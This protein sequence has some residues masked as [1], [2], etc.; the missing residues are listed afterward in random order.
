MPIKSKDGS[1]VELTLE[2]A[3]GAP[4]N[5]IAYTCELKTRGAVLNRRMF[6]DCVRNYA[7]YGGNTP[8]VLFHA[9]LDSAAHPD[10]RKAH[11]RISALQIGTMERRGMECDTLEAKFDWINEATRKDVETGA[12]DKCSVTIFPYAVDE[13]TGEEIGA[14]L[15]SLSLTNNPAL[16]DLPPL[17]AERS[18]SQNQTSPT[19]VHKTMSKFIA[20]AAT[21]G[22]VCRDEDQALENLNALGTEAMQVRRSLGATNATETA[23]K[24]SAAIQASIELPKVKAEIDAINAA[25]KARKEAEA[26]K[27]EADRVI[28]LDTLCKAKPHLA[29]M[30]ESLEFHSKSDWAGFQAK[31]PLAATVNQTELEKQHAALQTVALGQKIGPSNGTPGPSQLGVNTPQNADQMRRGKVHELAKQIMQEKK[32][33]FADALKQADRTVP[34]FFA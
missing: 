18:F 16:T 24:L 3:R 10:S 32:I 19:Q 4:W 21:F 9:D 31:Y 28:Y 22:F 25:E 1:K 8:V 30:R 7:R 26:I 23:S 27:L 20:L 34:R 11:A 29:E 33:P 12:L 6:D 15:Y 17:Q 5:K 13:E 14:Y 2:L